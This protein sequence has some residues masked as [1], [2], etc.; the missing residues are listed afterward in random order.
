MI[1]RKNTKLYQNPLLLRNAMANELI[2]PS[3][4]KNPIR[5]AGM[6]IIACAKMIGITL[7]ALTFRGMN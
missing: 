6:N 5:D 2:S 7:A 3:F 4:A 1:S